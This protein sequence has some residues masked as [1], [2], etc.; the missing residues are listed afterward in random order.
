MPQTI[1]GGD[2]GTLYYVTEDGDLL[3]YRD[4]RRDGV[5]GWAANSGSRIGTGWQDFRLVFGGPGGIIYAI[6]QNGDLVWYHDTRQDGSW[7]WAPNSGA[8]IGT[9]WQDFRIVF[10]GDQGVIY[11]I[12]QNGDL[13][14]YRDVPRNGT[15]GW[16][17]NSGSR[18]GSGWQD[19]R[20]VLGGDQGIIYGIKQNGDLLW[21]RDV[22]RNGTVG[23]ATNSGDIIGSGWSPFPHAVS[24]SGGIIYGVDAGG[25]LLWY[26]DLPRN[27]TPGWAQHSGEA[28]G[29]GWLGYQWSPSL[30]EFGHGAMQ[31]NGKPAIGPRRLVVILAEYDDNAA[32][33][34]PIFGSV[35]APDYYEKLAFGQPSPPFT[36]ASPVN[37]ASLD[38]YFR[39]CSLGR[40]WLEPGAVIGPIRMGVLNDKGP[41]TRSQQIIA[42]AVEQQPALFAAADLDG[43]QVVGSS[44]LVVL[45]VENIKGLQP[46]NRGNFA[47]QFQMQIGPVQLKKT[48]TLR[49]AFAGPLTPF[50]QVAH[51]VSHSLGTVDMYNSGA[52]NTLITLMG[53]YGFFA[54]DQAIV[55]L[56]A[57]HKLALGWCEPRRRRM[58]R[59]GDDALPETTP[60]QP[61]SPLLLWHPDRGASEYFLVEQRS[62]DSGFSRYEASLPDSGVLVWRVTPGAPIPVT[63]LGAPDLAVGGNGFWK[64]GQTTPP[65]KWS[66]GSSTGVRLNFH[67]PVISVNRP[68]GFAWMRVTWS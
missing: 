11:G 58:T 24:G 15:A 59:P 9:G 40:F 61:T 18:I 6:K 64:G 53:G 14:W 56:D 25:R 31:Q 45:I 19:F 1:L 5:A 49:V 42:R 37:P 62:R 33:D 30:A 17:A 38:G 22:P 7:A 68:S 44:E 60:S 29:S 28:V 2:N 63:H 34:F 13:L 36:T 46:A 67:D 52:G 35:H 8:V 43:D 26:R 48:I 20:I 23:W 66:D 50:Y 47:V 55:H 57:W 27:G 10:G 16:A 39:E 12:K 4:A 54:N 21:Y 65:L 32:G 3:W 41:E 51:E